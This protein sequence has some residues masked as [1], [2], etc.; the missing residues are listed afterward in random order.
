MNVLY[1]RLSLFFFFLSFIIKHRNG[2]FVISVFSSSESASITCRFVLSPFPSHFLL[3]HLQLLAWTQCLSGLRPRTAPAKS[4]FSSNIFFQSK[5]NTPHRGKDSLQCNTNAP[6]PQLRTITATSIAV[7]NDECI[8]DASS[9]RTARG[10]ADL[11]IGH[12]GAGVCSVSIFAGV[13]VRLRVLIVR[14]F[15]VFVVLL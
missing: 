7:V 13:G 4:Q 2:V 10:A 14:L 3:I 8:V 15:V 6:Q 11:C 9:R 5:R 12:W 1:S